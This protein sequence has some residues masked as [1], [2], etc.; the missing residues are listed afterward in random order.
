V[1]TEPLVVT[2][3]YVTI[4][5]NG[6]GIGGVNVCHVISGDL[7]SRELK[8]RVNLNNVPGREPAV[9][10]LNQINSTFFCVRIRDA[11]IC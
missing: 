8:Q 2:G 4:H 10:F 9:N 5:S 3:V 7:V 11:E 1:F 6:S